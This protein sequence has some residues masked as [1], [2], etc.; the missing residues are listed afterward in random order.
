MKKKQFLG[1]AAEQVQQPEN[2]SEGS[3]EESHGEQRR[4]RKGDRRQ[5]GNKD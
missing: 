1:A 4:E 5:N 3:S 2:T